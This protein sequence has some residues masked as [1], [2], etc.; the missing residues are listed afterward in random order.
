MLTHMLDDARDRGVRRVWLETGSMSFFAPARALYATAGFQ[1]CG[2]FGRYTADP[3]SVY[4]TLE[5]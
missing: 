5:L 2:P 1:P 3:N 4:M